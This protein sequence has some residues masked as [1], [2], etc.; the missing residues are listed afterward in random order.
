LR[1]C[2]DALGGVKLAA[3][4]A[5]ISKFSN[6]TGESPW[7][8]LT[9]MPYALIISMFTGPRAVTPLGLNLIPSEASG[10]GLTL[11]TSKAGFRDCAAATAITA[12]PNTNA[13]P[14]RFIHPPEVLLKSVTPEGVWWEVK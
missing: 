12:I 11:A 8:C 2:I 5:S 13:T 4:L 1:S 7:S 3:A 10:A 14:M 9:V 6:K